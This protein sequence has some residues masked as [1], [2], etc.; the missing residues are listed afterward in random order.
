MDDWLP[1]DTA[2]FDRDLRIAVLDRGEAHALAFPCRRAIG[3]WVDARTRTP[4]EV[5]PTHWQEW[6]SDNSAQLL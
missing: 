5:D 4:L 6:R 3:G 1:V 2:P